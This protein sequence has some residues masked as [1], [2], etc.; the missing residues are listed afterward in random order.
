LYVF[1]PFCLYSCIFS[2]KEN[3]CICFLFLHLNLIQHCTA[4][5]YS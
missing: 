2:F 3:F 4:F 1:H 5:H